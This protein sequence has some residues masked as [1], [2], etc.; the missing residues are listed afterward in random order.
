M[1]CERTGS[2]IRLSAGTRETVGVSDQPNVLLVVTDQERYDLTAAGD[3]A[4]ETP[5][6][7]RLAA[8]GLRCSRAYTP[9]AICSPARVSMLT[10]LYPHAHGVLSNPTRSALR[11]AIQPTHTTMGQVATDVGY[12]ADYVGK[13][14][15]A[16]TSPGEAGFTAHTGWAHSGDQTLDTAAYRA[17]A[18]DQ[19]IDPTAAAVT[20]GITSIPAEATQTAYLAERAIDRLRAYADADEPF[21]LRLD[22]PGPHGPYVVPRS[23]ADRYDPGALEPWPSFRETFAGKPAVHEL[24]PSYY[25]A[26][27]RTWPEWAELATR[28]FAF[29]TLIEEQ[30]ARV[31]DA[32]EEFGLAEDTLVIRT[33]DHGEFLGHHRQ[34][35]KGP[36]MYEDTY[37]VPLLARWPGVIDPGTETDAFVTLVDLLPTICGAIGRTAPP[38]QG[39]DL[40]PVFEGELAGWR[41]AVFAEYHGEP[42]TL[43]TQRMIRTDRYKFVYNG[44]DVNEL[45]DLAA[46]PHELSNLVDHPAYRSIRTEHAGRLGDWME[47]TDDHLDVARYRRRCVES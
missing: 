3:P 23:L 15:V 21:L 30:F 40:R 29:E 5:G 35:N 27:D 1:I 37:R 43:Y 13:W 26:A 17:F 4:V 32:L 2:E 7:D 39:R 38:V 47:R 20:D 45:Y 41:D 25:G 28:Y 19:G 46:D 9:T 6:S 36:L 16:G 31:L 33:S 11:T 8:E 34:G 44:P 24:H 18:R 22:F 10:G 42:E 12:H 14:H